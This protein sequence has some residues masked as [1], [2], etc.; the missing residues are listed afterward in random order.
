MSMDVGVA[1][2]AQK[3]S[4]FFLEQ[5]RAFLNKTVTVYVSGFEAEKQTI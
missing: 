3:P 4:P 1:M 2:I 5:K